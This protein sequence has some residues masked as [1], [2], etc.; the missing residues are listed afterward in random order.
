LTF[1]YEKLH[2]RHKD[3]QQKINGKISNDIHN[4]QQVLRALASESESQD[5]IDPIQRDINTF[6]ETKEKEKVN[7][8]ITNIG[9][10]ENKKVIDYK[11]KASSGWYA[12]LLMYNSY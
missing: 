3:L 10:K 6:Q 8:N 11:I 4:V 7:S 1:R 12:S 2:K 9:I 5:I